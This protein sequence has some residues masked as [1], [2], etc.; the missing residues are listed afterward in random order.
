MRKGLVLV[1]LALFV[2][3]GVAAAMPAAI[4]HGMPNAPVNT[5]V[6]TPNVNETPVMPIKTPVHKMLQ[7]R[8]CNET[9]N[10][11]CV[12][13]N[14]TMNNTMAQMHRME[15]RHANVTVNVTERMGMKKIRVKV[16]ERIKRAGGLRGIEHSY[17]KVKEQYFRLKHEYMKLKM[18]GKLDFAHEKK[19]CMVA[20]DFV[21]AW[22]DRM[23]AAILASNLNQTLKDQLVA[24]LEQEKLAFEE[25]LK[26]VNETENPQQLR[27][28]VME[29]REQWR[30][31]R[32]VVNEVALEVVVAKLDRTISIAE[33]L[34]VKLGSLTNSTLL[35]DYSAKVQEA[36]SYVEQAKNY[37]NA[38]NVVMAREEL[39]NA[40]RALKEAFAD[41]REIVREVNMMGREIGNNAS[42]S[43]MFGKN[44]GQ[45]NVFGNG[46]FEF[47]GS[48]IVV[49]TAS[50]ATITYT[51]NIVSITGFRANNNTLS[52]SGK[53]T[54]EGNVTVKVTGENVHMFVKGEGTARLSGTGT[55]WFKNVANAQAVH[56]SLNG[57]AEVTL[58][59]GS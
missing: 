3:A 55:Y 40:V 41:A 43:G 12:C 2:C 59:G 47:S 11:T 46:T 38:G 53:V 32:K 35:E 8:V 6:N 30:Q 34:E 50:N 27:Q 9:C 31:A 17:M 16:E 56:E 52:G 37:I 4:P 36:K 39:R 29:L 15:K 20:G 22:F 54:I 42:M 25:K 5:P 7:K 51:G 28:V 26:L 57:T 1:V 24:K 19:F 21:L 13:T 14:R 44:T 18:E 49:I 45:L 48:G 10:G 23:E 58:G 33:K